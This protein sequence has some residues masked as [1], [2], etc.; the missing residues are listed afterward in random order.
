[1]RKKWIWGL[2]KISSYKQSTHRAQKKIPCPLLGCRGSSYPEM[3]AATGASS[4]RSSAPSPKR[5]SRRGRKRGRRHGNPVLS[6]SHLPCGNSP[7]ARAG[8]EALLGWE[9]KKSAGDTALLQRNATQSAPT[10]S[11]SRS[12]E[13][14]KVLC[15]ARGHGSRGAERFLW[16][17]PDHGTNLPKA[18]APMGRS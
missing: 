18:P 8:D 3:P 11:P 14:N 1:M 2:V 15:A 9:R 17:N 12:Q 10:P 7:P 4:L 13:K 16:E 5:P 6:T